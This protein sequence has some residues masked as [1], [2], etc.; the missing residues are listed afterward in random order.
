MGGRGL[1]AML[2]GALAIALVGIGCGGSD[3][4]SAE[5]SQVS[6]DAQLS[7]K[8]FTKKAEVVCTK[9]Y[10]RVKKGYEGFTKAHGGPE[11][12]FDDP[13]VSAEYANDVIL[14]EKK[15][16]V[17]ELEALGAP[18][19][20]EEKYEELIEAY[21][22]GIEVG[23]EDPQKVMSSTGVFAYATSVAQGLGL[24]SCRY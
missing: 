5:G 14:A 22:E 10:E 19:G 7:S 17:E 13:D 9:N 24:E 11:N 18:K 20:D 3:S 2:V 4:G 21:D 8:A 16:T 23:E 1:L 12:A 6:A 15:K